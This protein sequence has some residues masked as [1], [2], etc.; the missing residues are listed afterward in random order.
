MQMLHTTGTN[1]LTTAASQP[2]TR[3][4]TGVKTRDHTRIKPKT[5]TV[6]PSTARLENEHHPTSKKK[7]EQE[8]QL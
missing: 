2:N 6:T 3:L 7:N 4:G 8:T 1:K 5:K